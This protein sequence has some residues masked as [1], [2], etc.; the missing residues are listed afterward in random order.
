MTA[1]RR[2][3]CT[4]T[5]GPITEAVSLHKHVYCVAHCQQSLYKT[6]EFTNWWE[7]YSDW[8]SGLEMF[9]FLVMIPKTNTYYFEK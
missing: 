8:N 1:E 5:N 3:S 4:V 2:R 6:V 7:A 9:H